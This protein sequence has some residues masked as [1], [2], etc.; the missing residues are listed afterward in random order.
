MRIME[1]IY[2]VVLKEKRWLEFKSEFIADFFARILHKCLIKT[3]FDPL[4]GISWYGIIHD[5][6]TY[7][8][9]Y[10]KRS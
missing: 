3:S 8:K 4:Y 7:K 10:S 5:S 2:I 9:D 1:P 6:Y